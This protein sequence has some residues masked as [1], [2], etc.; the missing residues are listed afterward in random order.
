MPNPQELIKLITKISQTTE[1]VQIE[2]N[3]DGREWTW[4]VKQSNV[5]ASQWSPGNGHQKKGD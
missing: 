5:T 1:K 3:Y 4:K 2:A